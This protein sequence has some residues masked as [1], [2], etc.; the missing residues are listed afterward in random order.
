MPD[1]ENTP[2]QA[3]WEFTILVGAYPLLERFIDRFFYWFINFT[4]L[5]RRKLW[6]NLCH[7]QFAYKDG[8][9]RVNQGHHWCLGPCK[10]YYQCGSEIPWSFRLDCHQLGVAVHLK[11]LVIAMLFPR[12]QVE[13]IYYLPPMD[14]WP[15]W[16][17]E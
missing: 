16:E 11:N 1:L 15:D 13:V 14:G 7:C 2:S 10:K 17:G 12:H 4:G 5:K 9:L 6:L 8:S 3:L